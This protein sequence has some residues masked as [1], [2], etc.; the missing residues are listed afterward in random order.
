MTQHHLLR[1]SS[2]EVG[3]VIVSVLKNCNTASYHRKI[4]ACHILHSGEPSK[5]EVCS[6]IVSFK[7]RLNFL[8]SKDDLHIALCTLH[9]DAHLCTKTRAFLPKSLLQRTLRSLTTSITTTWA[10]VYAIH[11][12]SRLR[13]KHISQ[14]GD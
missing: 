13:R 14:R 10:V 4:T 3:S 11:K 2:Y 12:H 8:S 9:P 5:I 7:S 6:V 1:I